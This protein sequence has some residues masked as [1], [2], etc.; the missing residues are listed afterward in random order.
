[1]QEKERAARRL[2]VLL[3]RSAEELFGANR[4]NDFLLSALE[5][6]EDFGAGGEVAAEKLSPEERKRFAA[7]L[8]RKLH[9]DFGAD[10]TEKKLSSFLEHLKREFPEKSIS[11][12]V[13]PLIPVGFLEGERLKF[14]SKEELEERVLEKTAE[15]REINEHLEE[16]IKERTE[17]LRRIVGEQERAAHLLVRRDLELT[18]ANER[19]RRM[20]EIKSGFISVVAHQLRTPLSGIKWTL[21]LVL[22]G[23]L[24]FLAEEQRAFLLKANESNDRMI[25]LVND[26]L[27]ADRI[28]SGKVRYSFRAVNLLDLA[29]AVLFELS[30]QAL[31]RGVSVRFASRPKS[32]PLVHGDGEQL[33]AVFQNLLDN[34][35]KYSRPQ[36]TIQVGFYPRAEEI[37]VSIQDDGIGIPREQQKNIFDRFFRAQN[38]IKA[39]TEGSGLGLFI[40]RS[41]VERHGGRIWFESE[42]GKG[43][44]F[45]FTV[46][47]ERGA[48]SGGAAAP[49]A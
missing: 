36:G 22:N 43:V 2:S 26:M 38:A 17:E 25:A 46:P 5:K 10:F 29:D 12:E 4:A 40:V 39:E 48:P 27:G 1:M 24:G 33:R 7:G 13:M 41:I 44:T 35:I 47:V 14:L 19:L 23:E 20:D 31:A 8:I 6:R 16:T 21:N 42:E 32:F 9:D 18:R 49:R 30:P 45:H 37:E 28:E 15:L 11:D 34:S 3:F